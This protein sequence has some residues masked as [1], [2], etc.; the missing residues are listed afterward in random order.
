MPPDEL[1]LTYTAEILHTLKSTSQYEEVLHLVVDRLARI[2][3][4]QTVAVILVDPQTEYLSV[5]NSFGL[6][7]TFCNAFR[8]GFTT[9]SVG[10]L[11]WTGKPIVISDAGRDPALTHDVRLEHDFGSCVCA[12]IAVHQKTLGYLHVDARQ[13]NAFTEESVTLVQMCADIAGLAVVKSTL[14]EQNLRLDRIDHETET[15]KYVPFLE[16]LHAGLERARTSHEQLAVMILDVDNFKSI[17]NTYGYDTSR[18]MLKEMAGIVKNQVRVSDACGR[19][20]FDEFIVMI[21]N[22][23]LEDAIARA[24]T[25]RAEIE[26]AHY[27]KLDIRSTVSIGLAFYPTSADTADALVQCAKGAL[28]EAQRAGRNNVRWPALDLHTVPQR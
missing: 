7:L 6:S 25:L 1:C 26:K 10:Q 17:A 11:L 8:R 16:R 13:E 27:T 12:Q 24:D 5:E 19:Y 15:E 4:A 28:F 18:A 23:S 2:F 9:A 20:G 21:G 14:T 22:S 3:K